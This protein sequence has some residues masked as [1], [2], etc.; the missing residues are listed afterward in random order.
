MILMKA[1]TRLQAYEPGGWHKTAVKPL[2]S[3]LVWFI[4]DWVGVWTAAPQACCPH[5]GRLHAQ[6]CA[7]VRGV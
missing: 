1:K 3:L 7:V 6:T 5:G 4:L 2:W